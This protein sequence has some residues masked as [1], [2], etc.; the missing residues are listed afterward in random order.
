M[1]PNLTGRTP[2]VVRTD[3]SINY[4]SH[5]GFVDRPRQPVCRHVRLPAH[6]VSCVIDR[7][8]SYTLYLNSDDGSKLWLDGVLVID[9]DGLHGMRELSA[10]R[11]LTAGLPL[12]PSRVL[13]ERRRGGAHHLVGRSG[14][15][16]AG[17]PGSR[18]FQDWA[19]TSRSSRTRAP[20]A[21]SS[22]R[23][24]T[25]TATSARAARAWT[26]YA[27]IAG[28]SGSNALRASPNTGVNNDTDYVT[29]SPRLDFRVNFVRT[30][31]HYVW[32]RGIGLTGNDDSVHVGLDG[33]AV[34]SADRITS[35]ANNAY[36]WTPEHHGRRGRD[37]Q[38]DQRRHSHHQRLDARG[39]HVIDKLLAH[40]ERG[41][42][43]GQLRADGV[44]VRFQVAEA[45]N[46]IRSH[47][48]RS[49]NVPRLT[50]GGLQD[51]S[52]EIGMIAA[53][54]QLTE[55]T[56]DVAL[57]RRDSFARRLRDGVIPADKIEG[58]DEE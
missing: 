48:S 28:F 39:R 15:R 31:M 26:L 6:R 25:T 46:T 50:A 33:A 2:N 14:D 16:Q 4:A 1:L 13:R 45:Q 32:V 9:N 10:T 51:Q 54:I 23:P 58:F 55:Q 7:P 52:A 47:S 35:F 37:D 17:D 27:A 22:W 43:A 20:T 12:A 8:A 40:D 44:L 53:D 19:A 41:F 56:V 49:A 34:A 29:S 24:R 21:W 11:T 18:L 3:A 5:L 38:C 36:S 57:G 42:P 30:G